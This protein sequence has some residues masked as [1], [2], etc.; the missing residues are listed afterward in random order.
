MEWTSSCAVTANGWPL[1]I[2]SSVQR[3]SGTIIAGYCVFVGMFD[4]FTYV[5]VVREGGFSS[6]GVDKEFWID[7]LS[8]ARA[9]P[10]TSDSIASSL[11][12]RCS[13]REAATSGRRRHPATP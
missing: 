8:L 7:A 13:A 5:L 1:N 2:G 10:A 6:E 4:L 11:S 3:T 12:K 9:G